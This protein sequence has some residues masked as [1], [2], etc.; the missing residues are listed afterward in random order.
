MTFVLCGLLR[1]FEFIKYIH[2]GENLSF[3]K[4][5]VRISINTKV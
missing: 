4:D 5:N 2:K 3:R 1:I